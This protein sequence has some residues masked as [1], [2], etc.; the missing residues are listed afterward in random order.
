[1]KTATASPASNADFFANGSWTLCRMSLGK[2]SDGLTEYGE[3]RSVSILP[4][5]VG[6]RREL[7]SAGRTPNEGSAALDSYP[8][9]PDNLGHGTGARWV[10]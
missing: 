10:K 1:M 3:P 8:K 6:V 7:K 2:A 4:F 5:T 9:N